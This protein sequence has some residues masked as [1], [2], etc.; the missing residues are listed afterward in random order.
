MVANP[1]IF[2]FEDEYFT[3]NP[4]VETTNTFVPTY[5]YI[6]PLRQVMVDLDKH[7][8][9]LRIGHLNA[10]SVPKHIDEV[11]RILKDTGLDI[12]AI[13]ESFI[14]GKVPEDRLQIDGYKLL[15][16]NRTGA[17]QGGLALY[18]RQ[19]LTADLLR[20]PQNANLPELMCAT[21]TINNNK[22]AIAVLYKRPIVPYKKMEHII[23]HLAQITC[24]YDDTI[25][26]GDINID[27]LKR[28][29]PDYKYLVSNII[30]PL[31]LTSIIDKPTRITAD[32]RKCI[33]VILVSNKDKCLTSGAVPTYSD[34]HLVYM[35]YDIKKPK[36]E[37]KKITIR[38]M[39]NFSSENFME[40]ARTA[41]WNT[42]EAFNEDDVNN[43][44]A[45]LENIINSLINKHAPFKTIT[46]DDK[47]LA[48][49]MNKELLKKMD[50][51][52]KLLEDWNKSQL[53][54]NKEA[55]KK[56]RHEVSHLQ[57]K[58][59]K[60]HYNKIAN[61]KVDNSKQFFSNL[62]KHN[63]V[64][65]KKKKATNKCRFSATKLNQAFLKNN[66]AKEDSMKVNQEIQKILHKAGNVEE[67]FKFGEI[68]KEETIK[69]IKSLK[70]SSCGE[71]GITGKFVKIA[72]EYL[73][74]PLSNIINS[75]FKHKVFPE[76][77]KRAIVKP[78]PKNNNPLT[79]SHYRPISL[80][81][82]FSKIHK[83]FATKEIIK[84][85]QAENLQD[86]YQ[87]AYKA[88]HGTITAL[89]NITDDIYNA[90][91]DSE[92][93]LLVLIDYSKAFDTINHRILYAKLKVLGFHKD[94]I[95]WVIAYLTDRKQ[96]VKTLEDESGWEYVKNGVP[97]GSVI[98]PL[99]FSI[100]VSDIRD[101]F[102]ECK[103]HMY[104]DDTQA[105]KRSTLDNVNSTIQKINSDLKRVSKYSDNNC[106]KINADK[107]NY[108]IIGSKD[109]TTK[110]QDIR[111]DDIVINNE[112]IKR[113]TVTTNLGIEFDQNLTWENQITK[114]VQNGYFKLKQLYRFKN[115]LSE[116]CKAR[117]IETYVLSQLN[118]GNTV[119]Q[120]ITK[121]LQNKL[122]K[123]QNSCF[124]FIYK[125]RKF[126]HISP[127]INEAKSLNIN[128]R[129][130]Y[131]GL[132]L[133][134]K[135]VTKK[136]PVYLCNRIKYRSDIHTRN[137]RN[138]NLIHLPRL[139]K[140]VKAGSFFHKTAIEYNK[141]LS[142]SI[143][144]T[145]SSIGSFKTRCK[146][147]LL[148]EQINR[149]N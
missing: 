79:E 26:M 41:P 97:Q 45:A 44:A 49:W 131:H 106:L 56:A 147:Y 101:V 114:Q 3:N 137:T 18:I 107:S 91:D 42:I 69:I 25:I 71:D 20:I 46:I 119:T 8:D 17:E 28:Y 66:N 134:H 103:Y 95:S 77:W 123:L 48:P 43:K 138:S 93:T 11:K 57:R 2:N 58:A 90:L 52:D 132:V 54:R 51:R 70:S 113:E 73:A 99:L 115:F 40:D 67:K 62:K 145:D 92:L 89:L 1:F 53:D 82:V 139:K 85:L 59:K 10:S 50:H 140:N 98:G 130:K 144:S 133:M 35:A 146:K 36:R 37:K 14:K 4:D 109:H 141:I 21:V 94:A 78:I 142:K 110:L 125:V 124:R 143:I 102:E 55:F 118:Y 111:L 117:L 148:E 127:Y 126:E 135:I 116:K 105:Y 122:Q 84:F 87:S 22:I 60:Q 136:A 29:S 129:T 75:S 32:S 61:M 68:T 31:S 6:S 96:K 13:T 128:A 72:A 15:N 112:P 34:H 121:E 120:N 64:T 83:K 9:S 108:I 65:D 149:P 7:K 39:K 27:M 5:D 23:E 81:S 104:A 38:D 16:V 86:I 88:N 33:D 74:Q 47:P 30:Q 24:R 76:Q 63:I 80:L 19:E 100:L 12:L